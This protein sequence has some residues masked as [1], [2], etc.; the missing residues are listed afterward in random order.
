MRTVF[1]FLFSIFS[2]VLFAQATQIDGRVLDETGAPM[3][4]ANVVLLG[5]TQVGAA[6][7]SDGRFRL[8]APANGEWELTISYVG[9]EDFYT[10]FSTNGKDNWEFPNVRMRLTNA[11]SELTVRAVRAGEQVPFA[12]TDVDRSEIA[13]ANL[14][15]DVPFLL[16]WTPSTVVTSDAGTG[17]GYTGIRIRGSDPTRINVTINGIPLNDSESQGVFW[18]NMPDFL[19]STESIQ[20]QR[21]V[22]TSTNGAGA[23][24]AS[25]NLSTMTRPSLLPSVAVSGSVG[26]FGTLRGNIQAKSGLFGGGWFAEG[27]L[28]HIQSDGYI[29]RG[30]ADLNSWFGK[31]GY[32]SDKQSLTLLAFGGNERTY[33][34]WNGVPVQYIDDPELRTFNTAGLERVA[35]PYD[36]E[37]DDYS[38]NHVQLHYANQ[39]SNEW[40]L[41]LAGHYTKGAGFFEQYKADQTLADYLLGETGTADVVRRLWLDNDFYGATA[42]A[43]YTGANDLKIQLG[44]AVN[45]YDGLHYGE[46]DLATEDFNSPSRFYENDAQKYEA[47]T[48]AKLSF[49][50]G[51]QWL[52]YTDV[53]LRTINYNFEGLTR[54]NGLV[55]QEVDYNF[56]NPKAGISYRPS[57]GFRT[58][59]SFAVAHHEPNRN[60]LVNSSPESRPVPEKLFDTEIGFEKNWQRAA[61]SLN[62]Y[63]MDYRDQLVVTGEL[64]D[65]GEYTRIN[66]PDSYRRGVELTAGFQLT[67]QLDLMG[68]ATFSQNRVKDFIE[69]IDDWDTFEQIPNAVSNAPLALSP[70]VISGLELGY[71]ILGK[72]DDR[73][74]AGLRAS[75]L[76]KYV[77][78]QYLDNTGNENTKLDSYFFSDFR[79]NAD[80]PIK[81]GFAKRVQANLIVRNIFNG[82]FVTN[83]WTY[84]FRSAGYNPVPDDPYA[85]SEGNGIYNLTGLYPQA[86]RNFLLGVTVVF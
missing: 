45:F 61:V 44:A 80:L 39:V 12:R 65:V 63:S 81:S 22:G 57:N 62:L 51:D 64:N 69:F 1:T 40:T 23:F 59:A 86:G 3:V 13:E 7:D 52:G 24:G 53:Q 33:Q 8:V 36:N 32:Q 71:Q 68:N 18:V 82:Q 35:A 74:E 43:E 34:A 25:I 6:T 27:R 50:L 26:S 17:I 54:Q 31:V 75:L 49:P 11:L 48:F 28:S 4:D 67:E 84:R 19:S 55:D 83:G 41:G 38:Q 77:G 10:K 72:R 58:Y 29:D 47:N 5:R 15:Q 20:I 2:L 46:A 76:G 78:E 66:V 42:N 16:R 70:N 60:D 14:G 21:G 9:Y 30:T 73:S 85:R 79:L 56:F 37:V